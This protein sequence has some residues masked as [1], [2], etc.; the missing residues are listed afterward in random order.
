MAYSRIILEKIEGVARIA[1]N[2]PDFLNSLDTQMLKEMDA[3][4]TE[5][6]ADNSLRAVILTGRGRAFCA[7]ADLKEISGYATSPQKML[8]Y[9][10]VI[11]GLFNR[12]DNFP[13]PVIA[14]ING[15]ALAGGLELSLACDL[16]IAAADARL[17]DQHANFGLVAGAGGSQRLPRTIGARRAK[18]LLFTGDWLAA[19]EAERLG[20]VNRVVPPD[21][22]EAEALALAKKLS[23]RSPMATKTV[24]ALV[25]RGMQMALPDALELEI[26]MGILHLT[27]TEDVQEGLKAF[28]EKRK[29]NF[30]GR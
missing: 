23:E 11:H 25:N 13:K 15:M 10:R 26:N 17:G 3:A 28:E 9:L 7:G 27:G 2:R 16:A 21:K 5:I 12:L 4:L 19:P 18:E 8:A 20:L 24:K 22:L 6:E 14:A 30:P 29:P 1:L